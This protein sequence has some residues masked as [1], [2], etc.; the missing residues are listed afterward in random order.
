MDNNTVQQV[1]LEIYRR[2]PEFAG[3]RPDV[4][5]APASGTGPQATG[6]QLTYKIQA[7]TASNQKI[8]RL[9]RVNVS[10]QGKILKVATSR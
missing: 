4:K 2:Y 7:V 3:A 1:N 10:A 8:T 6:Y 9:L 5:S